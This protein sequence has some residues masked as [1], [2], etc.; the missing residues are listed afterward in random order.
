MEPLSEATGETRTEAGKVKRSR[1]LFSD[2]FL[3]NESELRSLGLQ[4]LTEVKFENTISNRNYSQ[5]IR[6]IIEN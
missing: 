1:V 5:F 6:D 4:T 2:M 3:A